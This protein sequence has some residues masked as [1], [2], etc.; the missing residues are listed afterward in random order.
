MARKK[1][2]QPLS[3]EASFESRPLQNPDIKVDRSD[4][5][6]ALL[7]LP[8]NPKRW[9]RLLARAMRIENLERKVSLDEL[10]TYVW[11]MCDG[12]TS[13]RKMIQRF[14]ARYKLSR[15]EAEVSIVQYLRTLAKR[16]II[17][18]LVPQDSQKNN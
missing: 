4:D 1:K 12:K 6:S 17:G 18:I 16:G 8:T 5:G 10:G 2:D 11:D 14:A 3:R 13:V 7:R 15:K 9:V